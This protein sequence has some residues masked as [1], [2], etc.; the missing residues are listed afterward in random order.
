MGPTVNDMA[1]SS[2]EAV[3]SSAAFAA[4]RDNVHRNDADTVADMRAVTAVAAPTGAE[5]DRARWLAGRFRDLGLEPTTDEVG[6]V[7]ALTP[8]AEPDAPVVAIV[9]HLDTVFS[10]ETD[11]ALRTDGARIHAPGIS[12][13]GRGLAGMLAVARALQAAGWPVR[14]PLLLV[15]TVGE[16]GVGDLRGAKHLVETWRHRL[17]TF[18]ALD[19][20]GA[21]RIIRVGVGSRRLRVTY[22]ARGGHSW[23]DWGAP[24]AIHAVGRA[25]AE[26]CEL[27]LSAEPRTTLTVARTGGGTSINAIPAQA[28]LE[29]DLRSERRDALEEL[30][31]RARD[32]L[33]R[34]ARAESSAAE[35]VG[36][37][38][39]VFGD[40]PAGA[41]PAD[42]PLVRLCQA[43]TRTINRVPELTSSSTD[44][45]VAMAAGIPAVAIGA[46]GEAGGM[47]TTSEW[48]ENDEGAL[49]IERALLIS[50]CAAGLAG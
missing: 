35:E 41:T 40:R 17:G 12:D 28:W 36:C 38:I 29:I 23:A 2:V 13:N 25:I 49:G 6:N 32:I 39:V 24:N 45:N 34:A 50:L 21:T 27:E 18:I 43:A 19:G 3:T 48:Y 10:A 5:A 16:E 33:L 9:A 47:H 30:E 15:G 26:L 22:T 7:L 42:H 4:A 31:T 8:A 20:A 11:L 37:D 14:A 46:G 44:A 1:Y